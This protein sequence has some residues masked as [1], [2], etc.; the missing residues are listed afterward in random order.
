MALSNSKYDAII[1]RYDDT[2]VRNAKKRRIRLAEVCSKLPEY[3]ALKKQGEELSFR[4]GLEAIN[5]SPDALEKLNRELSEIITTKRNLLI[6]AGYP[7]NY[8]DPI[9]NCP[10]CKDTGYI[11][12]EKCHCFRQAEITELYRQSN[13][14]DILEKENFSVLTYDYYYDDELEQM[15]AVIEKC[16]NFARD[17]DFAYDNLLFFGSP[18]T[19]KTFL[20]NCITKELLDKGHSVI[21]FTSTE[22]FDTLATY[23]F[24][25]S[26][27]S[28]DVL[29]IHEDIFSCDL[30]VIDDLGTELTNEFVISQLFLIINERNV[31]KRSTI[32]STNLSMNE[33]SQAYDDRIVSR[34][35]GS[36][37]FINPG[38][39]D[40]RF[41]I[42][43]L[44]NK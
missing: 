23:I 6:A 22:L 9:Y 35:I 25:N 31:R 12:N 40:L 5:G 26:D 10:D 43:K 1:R 32:I 38:T 2:R 33:L 42:K 34:I 4:L 14:S 44:K 36:Y 41:R 16:R 8:L 37:S 20:T 7:E 18:G 28:E 19:G 11:N 30:L 39:G 29:Q 24:R 13:I 27:A 17:F 15:K 21:Y 3:D